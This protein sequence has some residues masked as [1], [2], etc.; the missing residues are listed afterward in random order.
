MSAEQAGQRGNNVS[1]SGSGS[2]KAGSLIAVAAALWV[3]ACGP[4]DPAI[5]A[6]TIEKLKGDAERGRAIYQD[7]VVY[8]PCWSCH[9][10]TGIGGVNHYPDLHKTAK[11]STTAEMALQIIKP[12]EM[13]SYA[14]KLTDQQVADVIAYV[15]AAFG[16]SG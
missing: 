3:C 15:R 8:P 4:V 12:N 13:P 2:S 1:T 5:R 16:G 10:K 6:V 11:E 9:G 7:D 14:D